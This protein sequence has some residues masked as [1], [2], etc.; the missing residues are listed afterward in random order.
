M[1]TS[2]PTVSLL[3]A[4]IAPPDAIAYAIECC[5][6]SIALL[7]RLRQ[8]R[9]FATIVSAGDH[10]AIGRVDRADLAA[11]RARLVGTPADARIARSRVAELRS[12]AVRHGFD[13]D[14]LSALGMRLAREQF[15][16]ECPPE[17]WFLSRGFGIYPGA[18][19]RI[20]RRSAA[21]RAA[22]QARERVRGRE[23]AARLVARREADR[24]AWRR[25]ESARLRKGRRASQ[26]YY[27]PRLADGWR[28]GAA[29]RPE[30]L[31]RGTEVR[32][33]LILESGRMLESWT[34]GRLNRVSWSPDGGS[35]RAMDD[36][37]RGFVVDE[38][39]KV[40]RPVRDVVRGP[41]PGSA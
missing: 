9:Y 41:R 16:R 37:L 18:R 28:F 22:Q 29:I 21:S 35:P 24:L 3:P 31:A 27:L 36:L 8:A 6:P 30:S 19:T 15:A 20:D 12:E 40:V 38:A 34:F 26:R 14:D 2:T 39:A 17:R 7:N 25:N 33:Y 11:Q 4:S 23:E 32:A 13:P 10:S 1:T 5:L